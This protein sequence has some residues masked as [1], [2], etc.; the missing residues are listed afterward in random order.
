MKQA[1]VC[2]CVYVCRSCRT[3]PLIPCDY[4]QLFFHLDCLDPPLTTPPMNKW[5]CPNHPEHFVVRLASI[6]IIGVS[7]YPIYVF[8]YI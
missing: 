4:C 8:I 1:D 3:G 5:M 7:I 6:V 2:V